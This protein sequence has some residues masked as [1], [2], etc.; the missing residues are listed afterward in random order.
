MAGTFCQSCGN[1]R[2]ATCQ[3]LRL[4]WVLLALAFPSWSRGIPIDCALSLFAS[5]ARAGMRASEGAC[6]SS[7]SVN[8]A[9]GAG[10]AWLSGSHPARKGWR[11]RATRSQAASE[12]SMMTFSRRVNKSTV[13][14]ISFGSAGMATAPCRSKWIASF[15]EA[16][17]DHCFAAWPRRKRLHANL[18][19]SRTAHREITY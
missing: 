11:R 15:D 19:A 17:W 8:R 9:A 16:L 18:G 13:A 5:R 3:S 12:A 1:R 10:R 7:Q 4:F 14:G 2:P 6:T